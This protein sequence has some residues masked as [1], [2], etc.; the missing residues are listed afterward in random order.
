M[1]TITGKNVTQEVTLGPGWELSRSKR[2]GG[3]LVAVVRAV[4]V[5]PAPGPAQAQ[6]PEEQ[7]PQEKGTA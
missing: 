4:G 6:T 1:S 2:Y 7:G 5:R 3:T